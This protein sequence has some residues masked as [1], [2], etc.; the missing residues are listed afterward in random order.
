MRHEAD[1]WST[2]IG[3]ALG[4][5]SIVTAS[6]AAQPAEQT[7]AAALKQHVVQLAAPEHGGRGPGST[8][9]ERAQAYVEAQF[10]AIGLE[11]GGTR[12]YAAP[13]TPTAAEAG[14]EI[15]PEAGGWGALE[16]HNVVGILKGKDSAAGALVLA[17]HYDH[18]PRSAAGEVFAGADDNGSG[19]AALIELARRL[20]QEAPLRRTIVFLATSGEEEGLL[21]AK[22]YCASP[23]QPLGSTYAVLNF[24]TVGRMTDHKLYLLGVATATEWPEITRS[25]NLAYGFDLVTPEKAPF[26]SDQA[27]FFDHGI[28]VLHFFTGPN[29]DYHRASDTAEK[30]DYA[31]LGEVVN[32]AVDLTIFLAEREEPL[33]F[34]PPGAAAVKPMAPAG[35]PRRVSLGTIPDFAKES[36]G[37]LLSGVTPGSPAEAAGF[38]KGDVLIELGGTPVDNLSDFTAALKDHQPGDKVSVTVQR[39]AEKISKEV[40]LVERK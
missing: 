9:L 22:A 1:R 14:S 30:L 12:G 19:V 26:A 37:V 23:A 17:A 6:A 4:L 25:V 8:G 7:L 36:G 31:A 21:G 15:L 32:Y 18:L 3:G 35:G 28:P 38:Q 11:P 24:D 2:A 5:L 29:V 33:R 13:F 10:E 34:V 40:T 39:G 16:L 20:K 27:A